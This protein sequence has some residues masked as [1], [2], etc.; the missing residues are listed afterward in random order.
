MPA[1]S[2]AGAFRPVNP[3]IFTTA[4]LA[5]VRAVLNPEFVLKNNLTMEQAFAEF[6]DI[7]LYGILQRGE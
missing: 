7:F 6:F 4:L 5:T 2:K 3:L 1:G